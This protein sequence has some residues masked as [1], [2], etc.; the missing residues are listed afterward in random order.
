MLLIR[1]MCMLS[2]LA[3]NSTQSSKYGHH[4]KQTWQQVMLQSFIQSG[5][6]DVTRLWVLP[7]SPI[8][9]KKPEGGEE[10]RA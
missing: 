7:R 5:L 1:C 3:D 2:E 9:L 8:W 4:R 10:G 6:S